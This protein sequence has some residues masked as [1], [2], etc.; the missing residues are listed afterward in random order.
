M[1]GQMEGF[2]H[3][4]SLIFIKEKLDIDEI[5]DAI[6]NFLSTKE[7]INFGV[8]TTP[9]NGMVVRILGHKAEQLHECLKNIHS[10]IQTFN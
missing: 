1:M 9:A 5:C 6:T 8:S 4:A 2:T 7:G 3:Q 10:L